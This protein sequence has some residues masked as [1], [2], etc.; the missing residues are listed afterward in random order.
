MIS[1]LLVLLLGE[2]ALA[3][4]VGWL[5]HQNQELTRLLRALSRVHQA[6]ATTT[7]QIRD[8]R[9]LAEDQLRRVDG[10]RW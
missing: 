3:A 2:L 7:G 4:G 6:T 5:W 9:L 10:R 1:L 8:R